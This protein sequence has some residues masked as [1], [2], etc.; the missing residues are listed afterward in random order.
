MTGR[1]PAAGTAVA[2][3]QTVER[4]Q[5]LFEL[6]NS[7][8]RAALAQASAAAQAQATALQTRRLLVRDRDLV[9]QGFI[10]QA[11]LDA[12]QCAAAVVLPTSTLE[13][14]ATDLPWVLVMRDK[15]AVKQFV[16]LGLRGD[17]QVKVL[18]GVTAGEGVAPVS[19]N[20]VKAGQRVRARVQ[21]VPPPARKRAAHKN[22]KA[23]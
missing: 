4:G 7:D 14:A 23:Q 10:S 2:Q 9:A 11:A 18:S 19:K 12:A 1:Q 21:A 16:T 22:P 15:H 3:G 5:L 17:T 13:D 20:G 8:A 6:D